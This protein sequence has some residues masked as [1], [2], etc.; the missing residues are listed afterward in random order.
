M[1]LQELS[2][3]SN[4][5]FIESHTFSPTHPTSGKN[6]DFTVEIRSTRCDEML[7]LTNRYSREA[8]LKAAKEQRTGKV[9]PDTIEQAI[10]RDIEITCALTVGFHG[11]KN[12]GKE[13][14]TDTEAI[15][16]VLTQHTWLR[17]QITEEAANEQNFFKA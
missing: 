6:L 15:K 4:E 17:K 14:G 9:E 7:A 3:V 11:L 1:D 13:I 12:D 8:Q 16:A 5:R 2:G 10:A